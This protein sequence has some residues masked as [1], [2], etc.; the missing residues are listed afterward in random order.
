MGCTNSAALKAHDLELERAFQMEQAETREL[1][2][3]LAEKQHDLQRAQSMTTEQNPQV[4][5]LRRQLQ[6]K[7]AELQEALRQPGGGGPRA[8]A[9]QEEAAALERRQAAAK[10]EAES[11]RRTLIETL[12]AEVDQKVLTLKQH[13]GWVRELGEALRESMAP[14]VTPGQHSA[15]LDKVR[16]K[17]QQREQAKLQPVTPP[18]LSPLVPKEEVPPP[19][20]DIS[21]AGTAQPSGAPPISPRANGSPYHPPLSGRSV[22]SGRANSI[23]ALKAFDFPSVAASNDASPLPPSQDPP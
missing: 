21:V 5:D 2:R 3:Q 13:E 23:V 22:G 1:N 20:P 4:V 8:A 18:Q 19:K 17:Q 15:T 6:Q 7:Q 11:R 9:L 10:R 12:Q 14:G 16:A